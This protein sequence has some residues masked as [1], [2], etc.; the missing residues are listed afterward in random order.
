[1]DNE[2]EFNIHAQTYDL[3]GSKFLF[4]QVSVFYIK[5]SLSDSQSSRRLR[6]VVYRGS[7]SSAERKRTHYFDQVFVP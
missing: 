7:K 2:L 1:M 3:R 4:G 5:L 6:L